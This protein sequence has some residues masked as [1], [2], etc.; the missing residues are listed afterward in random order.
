MLPPL[1]NFID[2][3]LK[4][5]KENGWDEAEELIWAIQDYFSMRGEFNSED[6]KTLYDH[7][8]SAGDFIDEFEEEE[9][10]GCS[11]CTYEAVDCEGDV[12]KAKG[13]CPICGRNTIYVYGRRK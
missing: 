10:I 1:A 13:C 7:E 12:I 6:L 11:V 3:K 9:V 2:V 8:F 5:A 4:E